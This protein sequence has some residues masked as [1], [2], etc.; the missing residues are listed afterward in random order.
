MHYAVQLDEK[1]N[2]P[3]EGIK[4]SKIASILA[5]IVI[6]RA[7]SADRAK[8]VLRYVPALEENCGLL[9]AN[10]STMNIVEYMIFSNSVPENSRTTFTRHI[11]AS[12]I[13][14]KHHDVV[15][16]FPGAVQ[17]FGIKYADNPNLYI[18]S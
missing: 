7:T 14:S 6:G 8:G 5:A 18:S 11:C 17:N 1:S 2:S 12:K 3:A 10:V 9:F 13:I 4:L 16:S 15:P